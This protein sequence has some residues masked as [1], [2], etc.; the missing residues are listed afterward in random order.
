MLTSHLEFLIAVKKY[1]SMNKAAAEMFVTQPTITNAV[2]SLEKEL[3]CKI[4]ERSPSG[5]KFTPMGERIV[6]DAEIIV[7]IINGW[8]TESHAEKIILPIAFSQD[9]AKPPMMDLLLSYQKSHPDVSLK[10]VPSLKHGVDILTEK[11]EEICR[12]GLFSNTPAEVGTTAASAKKIGLQMAQI[13]S[14]QFYVCFSADN[15]LAQKDR[16]FL[17]DFVRKKVILKEGAVRFPYIDALLR[18]RCDCS[19]A[20]GNHANIMVA[21]LNDRDSISFRP[22]IALQEDVYISGGQIIAKPIEDCKME[23]N[24][25]MVYPTRSRQTGEEKQLMDY[26]RANAKQFDVVAD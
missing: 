7:S 5:I 4:I 3:G 16:V 6:E 24:K 11:S 8:K 26:I 22:E 2:R 12:F 23:I 9:S 20:M 19:T 17:S 1:R 25:F 13:A 18:I 15:P 10:F 21:L 14:S